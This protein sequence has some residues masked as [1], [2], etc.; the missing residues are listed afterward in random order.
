ML[1]KVLAAILLTACSVPAVAAAQDRPIKL[2]SD[3]KLLRQS[4]QQ[5][6]APELVAPEG[7]VPGDTLVFT[8]SYRNEGAS[9]VN[10]FVIVNPV[11]SDLV[12]TDEAAADTEVSVDGGARWGRLADL[13]IVNENG[14][15]RPATI[16]DV[17][18]MRWVFA[19]VAASA[20]GEVKF[21]ARVR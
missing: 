13:R 18:H 6:A 4:P 15:Q 20:A 17:T 2:Q 9:A 19:S 1:N 11:P 8:T 5:G 14:E 7:I 10:D 21:S 3:V 12:L 16:E